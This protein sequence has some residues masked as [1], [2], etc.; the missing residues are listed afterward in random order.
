MSSNYISLSVIDDNLGFL[1]SSN[2]SKFI[3]NYINA[4][5]Y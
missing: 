1:V 4:L 3:E 5:E 2:K